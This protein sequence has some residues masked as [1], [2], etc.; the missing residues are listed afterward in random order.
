MTRSRRLLRLTVPVVLGA[1]AAG[2]AWGFWSGGVAEGSSGRAEVTSVEPVSAPTATSERSSV[3][4]TWSPGTLAD[5]TPVTGYVVRRRGE[6]TGAVT[7]AG[8]GCTGVL[9]ATTCTESGVPDGSWSYS[10]TPRF[11]TSWTGPASPWSAPLTVDASGPTGGS[12]SATALTGTGARWSRS[13]TLSLALS[14]GT[15]P[16]GLAP[17]GAQLLRSEST[18]SSSG[19]AEGSC[20]TTWS[21][22][23]LVATDPATPFA[24]TVPTS[25]RC[26][27]YQYVVAD[28]R[29]NTTAYTSPNVKVD[30]TAPAAPS[31]SLT[32][33]ASTA[34]SGTTVYYRPAASGGSFRVASTASDLQSGIAT[35]AFPAADSGWTRT[36]T[37]PVTY[38]WTPG[39]AAP[40]ARTVTATNHAGATS[41][42]STFTVVAD[43]AAPTGGS[44]GYPDG[45]TSADHVTVGLATGT[46]AGSGIATAQLQRATANLSDGSCGTFGAFTDAVHA[47]K[48]VTSVSEPVTPGTCYVFRYV[49]TDAVGNVATYTS[50]S[51]VRA[52]ESTYAAVV[53]AT[54]GLTSYWRLGEATLAADAFVGTAGSTV[55]SRPG[56]VS[57]WTRF[58]YSSTEAVL[59]SAG[60]VRR[61]GATNGSTQGVALYSRVEPDT[62]DYTVGADVHVASLVPGDSVALMGRFSLENY[63]SAYAGGYDQASR[64][65]QLQRVVGEARTTLATSPVQPL[66]VGRTYR[67]ELQLHGPAVTLYVDGAAVVSFVDSPTTVITTRGE[68]GFALGWGPSPSAGSTDATGFQVDNFRMTHLL[69]DSAGSGS[70]LYVGTPWLAGPAAVGGD[71]DTSVETDGTARGLASAPIGSDLGLELWFRTSQGSGGGTS[72]TDGSRL[73]EAAVGGAAAAGISVSSDGHLVAGAA[74]TTVTSAA[75]GY[76]DAQWHH[77]V[78]VRSPASDTVSLYVDGV[79]SGSATGVAPPTTGNATVTLGTA[80]D[81]GNGFVGRLDEVALYGTALDASTVA[82]H[83]AAR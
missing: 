32:A 52:T 39:A 26:Y 60:R 2:T 37:S 54:A 76:T 23:A 68:G 53:R 78:L 62:A 33:G 50:G 59:T 70:G 44:I 41:S 46:D 45:I 30:T 36:G 29:G 20:A 7:A 17:S 67:L 13:L 48:G 73:V 83:Y 18:V 66:T 72:W 27:R 15:D 42:A 34:V 82:T 40:G 35:T 75:G 5:G 19:A 63:A 51:V 79:V 80:T 25:G 58:S 21:A 6:A 22:Y 9:T 77:V 43:A 12:V 28:M 71:Q 57:S 61:V 69:E 14:Q 64:T 24:D 1:V 16:Q 10:V 8:T 65:W 74:G 3:T 31:L 38:A 55:Q 4:L 49:V 56:E 81:G 47:G 11:A